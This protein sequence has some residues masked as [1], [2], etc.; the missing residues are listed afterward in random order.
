L[1]VVVQSSICPSKPLH[2]LRWSGSAI[3]L[4][5]GNTRCSLSHK[6]PDLSITCLLAVILQRADLMPKQ[7]RGAFV[8]TVRVR[9]GAAAA[10]TATAAAAAA[11]R[12]CARV[13]NHI[14]HWT[15][16]LAGML[17]SRYRCRICISLHGRSLCTSVCCSNSSQFCI[18]LMSHCSLR[19]GSAWCSSSHSGSLFGGLRHLRATHWWLGKPAS[20]QLGRLRPPR[21]RR[22][23]WRRRRAKVEHALPI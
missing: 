11:A 21:R 20:T 23:R 7:S 14:L 1:P 8:L 5:A 6:A 19:I 4:T 17:T 10:A 3:S 13:L 15:A 12:F 18:I 16:L 22:L 9:T 2:T